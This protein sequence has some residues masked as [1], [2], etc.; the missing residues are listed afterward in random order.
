LLLGP[1]S[2]SFQNSFSSREADSLFL[3]YKD[4]ERG[5]RLTALFYSPSIAQTESLKKA[6]FKITHYGKYSY[7]SFS[8]GMN[9]QK[10]T[11][12]ASRSPLVFELKESQ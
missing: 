4:T 6:A 11:W 9:Q 10:G 7:L 2:F 1:S 5:G 3:V 12:S 8:D